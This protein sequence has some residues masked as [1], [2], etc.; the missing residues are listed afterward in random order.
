MSSSTPP[1]ADRVCMECFLIVLRE[2]FGGWGEEIN[3]IE[4]KEKKEKN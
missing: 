2:L 4:R 3:K 1:F